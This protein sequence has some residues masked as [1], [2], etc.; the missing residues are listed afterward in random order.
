LEK[1]PGKKLKQMIIRILEIVIVLCSLIA[2]AGLSINWSAEMGTVF[3]PLSLWI[4][5]FIQ[6]AY[7]FRVPKPRGE[8][9]EISM[10]GRGDPLAVPPKTPQ[11]G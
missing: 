3:I 5:F 9:Q 8:E 11:N 10:P 6:V 1:V 7:F 4:L 2:A